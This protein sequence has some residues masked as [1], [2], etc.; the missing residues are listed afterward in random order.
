MEL[1]NVTF[2]IFVAAHCLQICLGSCPALQ[3]PQSGLV[4]FSAPI[5]ADD[6]YPSLSVVT[7]S[8]VNGFF[9]TEGDAQRVCLHDG[10]WSGDTPTCAAASML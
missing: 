5:Q 7:Y 4:D 1:F 8:C 6:T 3:A 10:T 2:I 9:L